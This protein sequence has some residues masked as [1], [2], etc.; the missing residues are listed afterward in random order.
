MHAYA[1]LMQQ[2]SYW[3]YIDINK[4]C[5]CDIVPMLEEQCVLCDCIGL[6]DDNH[7]CVD[8]IIW[9]NEQKWHFI[10]KSPWKKNNYKI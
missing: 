1:V 5:H 6:L 3:R 9:T 10:S 2:N 7:D 8:G 4:G